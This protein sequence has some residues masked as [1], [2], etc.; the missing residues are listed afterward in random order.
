MDDLADFK[1]EN[2]LEIGDYTIVGFPF[3]INH[4]GSAIM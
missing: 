3:F 2:L 1:F 4:D